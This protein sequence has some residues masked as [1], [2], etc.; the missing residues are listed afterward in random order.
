M[1]LV[2]GTC[3][4]CG[5]GKELTKHHLFPRFVRKLLQILKAKTTLL[6]I[7][8]WLCRGCHADLETLIPKKGVRE[9]VFYVEVVE[10]FLGRELPEFEDHKRPLAQLYATYCSIV[11]K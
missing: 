4:K 3:V 5:H 1:I 9:F 7:H 10:R 2:H 11:G 6:G 8:I